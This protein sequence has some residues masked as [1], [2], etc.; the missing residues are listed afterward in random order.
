MEE[1]NMLPKIGS[2]SL[3]E[4]DLDRRHGALVPPSDLLARAAVPIDAATRHVE[5][6]GRRAATVN[7][8]LR[9]APRNIA[10]CT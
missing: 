1:R 8:D 4:S 6:R 10:A 3:L 7:L 5:N 9:A 2:V